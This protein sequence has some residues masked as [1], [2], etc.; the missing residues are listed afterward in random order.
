[1]KNNG[2][3]EQNEK[4]KAALNEYLDALKEV[5][6]WASK[7][8]SMEKS[9]GY[10]CPDVT[11]ALATITGKVGNPTTSTVL[12]LETARENELD[13]RQYARE[14]KRRVLALIQQAPTA[15][16]RV[17]LMRRYIDGMGW[18]EVAEAADKSRTWATNTHGTALLHIE[19]PERD[20]TK[21]V[22][23]C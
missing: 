1:M 12:E 23:K 14:A 16:Q 22:R 21:S 7:V 11:T 8:E 6:Y 19:L 10:R 3:K 4:K 5:D 20:V 18:E 13:A 15:D 9:N 2:Q 17:L